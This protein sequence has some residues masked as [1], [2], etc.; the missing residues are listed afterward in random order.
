MQYIFALYMIRLI[1]KAAGRDAR[2]P[3]RLEAGTGAGPLSWRGTV[4]AG[5]GRGHP[6]PKE[7]AGLGAN[8]AAGLARYLTGWPGLRAQHDPSPPGKRT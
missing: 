5:A 7:P 3:D 4:A 1:F 6:K 8:A 2:D